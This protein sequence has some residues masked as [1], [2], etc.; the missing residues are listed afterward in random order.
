MPLKLAEVVALES[1]EQQMADLLAS[2]LTREEFYQLFELM[3]R[4]DKLFEEI[5]K[6]TIT[7]CII[8]YK[9]NNL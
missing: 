9:E 3:V 5:S 1:E 7:L 2:K 6:K 4:S 8:Q